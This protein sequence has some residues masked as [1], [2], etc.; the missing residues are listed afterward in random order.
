MKKITIGI[1][2][3]HRIPGS[4]M[5]INHEYTGPETIQ[6]ITA[7]FESGGARVIQIDAN[8]G[9][10]ERLSQLQEELNL[11]FNIAEG[12]P[13][14]KSRKSLVAGM[15]ENL[16]IPYTGSGPLAHGIAGEKS[17]TRE[18]LGTRVRQ[19]RW[20]YFTGPDEELGEWMRYP[21]MVKPDAEGSSMGIT[22]DCVVHSETEL[23]RALRHVMK[24]TRKHAIVEGF[25]GGT[26]YNNGVIGNLVLPALE[27][28][29]DKMPEKPRVKD[30]DVKDICSNYCM[31]V[32]SYTTRNMLAIQAIQS[33]RG[34]GARDYSR[35][36]FRSCDKN[37]GTPVFL[38]INALPC[39]DEGKS[40]MNAAAL[41]GIGHQDIMKII[42]YSSTKRL[43]EN[44][45]YR[46][47]LVGVDTSGFDEVYESVMSGSR[48][49]D[50]I[51]IDGAIYRLLE[52]T[53]GYKSHID[54][55]IMVA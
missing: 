33:H 31:P 20:Q 15:L 39:F 55:E 52:A 23:R 37:G 4:H 24:Q 21:L 17:R 35:S 41:A 19:P 8:N 46:E 42:V 7:A 51:E 10:Y 49:S 14:T 27:F 44:P 16:E 40:L 32:S 3:N 50:V 12:P 11:A 38:E 29:L 43:S 47:K 9:I 54:R 48:C 36:D 22:Q 26:E 53:E 30:R 18:I 13:N 1:V 34:V 2:A 25:L 45:R 6:A 28:D 5:E